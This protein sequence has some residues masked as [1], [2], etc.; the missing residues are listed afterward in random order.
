MNIREKVFPVISTNEANLGPVCACG[1]GVHAGGALHGRPC[2]HARERRALPERPPSCHPGLGGWRAVRLGPR[3]LT[4]LPPSF[5]H[6]L[7]AELSASEARRRVHSGR[8]ASGWMRADN[9]AASP[10]RAPPCRLE[11]QERFALMGFNI[12]NLI[13]ARLIRK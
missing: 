2:T 1:E 10:I 5:L 3:L 9:G 11:L 4:G 8:C 12:D 6:L 7:G 13:D